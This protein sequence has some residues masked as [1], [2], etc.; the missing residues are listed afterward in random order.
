ML[1]KEHKRHTY[2]RYL[3]LLNMLMWTLRLARGYQYSSPTRATLRPKLV[4]L[5]SS[6][7]LHS[8]YTQCLQQKRRSGLRSYCTTATASFDG[9]SSRS[10]KASLPGLGEL[11][12]GS[13]YHVPVM[14]NEVMEYLI[15]DRDGLY[16]DC[17]LGGGGHSNALLE[18][19]G[20]KGRVIGLD[21]DPQALATAS[22][23]L[24][25][26]IHSGRFVALRSNFADA[27]NAIRGAP[28]HIL[29][30]DSHEHTDGVPK[31]DGMLLDLGVSSRQLDDA[32]RGFS[33]SED[34]PLDMRMS[35]ADNST[36][37]AADICNETDELVLRD[38]IFQLGE[39]RR[40]SKI[41]KAIVAARPVFT[42]RQLADIVRSAVP[43]LDEKKSV[44]RV[45]QAFRIYVNNELAALEEGLEQARMLVRPGGRVVILSYHSLE[46]RRAK[47][48]LVTGNV[49]ERVAQ[50]D[51]YG[52]VFSPWKAVTRKPVLPMEDEIAMNVRAR[53]A[54]LRVGQ[55]TETL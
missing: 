45:F 16:V 46:D 21:R 17:T 4:R 24:S 19:L 54:K 28:A 39:E 3:F 9:E 36:A 33:Y 12:F 38:I 40:S 52:D 48:V 50:R 41:A 7:L 20:P 13:E 6:E 27:S 23:R 47:R 51:M 55:R 1:E 53:S 43:R 10:G 15:T 31:V 29:H 35:I 25:V 42:T 5:R 8:S 14:C 34:G 44:A 2:I 26:H 11:P 49:R 32:A 30:G 18:C 37:T 22:K